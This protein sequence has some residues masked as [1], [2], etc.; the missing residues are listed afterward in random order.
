[1]S[2]SRA[3]G[4]QRYIPFKLANPENDKLAVHVVYGLYATW[5]LFGIPTFFGVVLAYLKR[6]DVEGSYLA[7]HITWQIRSFWVMFIGNMVASAL[8]STIILMPIA[9]V[10]FPI[11]W[12]WFLWRVARGWLK[13]S[14]EEPIPD[15]ERIL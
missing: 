6:G 9:W 2:D 8:A 12:V 11:V 3:V 1:M 5:F 4:F 10:L 14:S 7:S 13:L 15:P